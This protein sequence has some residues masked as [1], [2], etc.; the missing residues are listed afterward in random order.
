MA[1]P[2]AEPDGPSQGHQ[3]MSP[4][5]SATEAMVGPM[6]PSGLEARM[7]QAFREELDRGD[8]DAEG[9]EDRLAEAFRQEAAQG[10]VD[11]GPV[12]PRA[13]PPATSAF[14]SPDPDAGVVNETGSTM[15]S[16]LEPNY[17]A[18]GENGS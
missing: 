3:V 14:M 5:V 11:Q 8:M 13:S 18:L 6:D 9:L 17:A 1:S 7:Q 16:S 2:V 10:A 15:E 4:R 12:T